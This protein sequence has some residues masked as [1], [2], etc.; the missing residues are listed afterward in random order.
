MAN[1][2]SGVGLKN[3]FGENYSLLSSNRGLLQTNSSYMRGIVNNGR[4]N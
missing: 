4:K 3:P 2:G 1:K